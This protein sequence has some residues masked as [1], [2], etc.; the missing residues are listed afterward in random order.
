[1]SKILE[2]QPRNE[3]ELVLCRWLNAPRENVYRAWT[4][5]RIMPKWFAPRPWTTARVEV[6]VRAGGSTLVV[7]KSPEGQE[8]PC[9][10]IYLEVIPGKKIVT[11]DAYTKAWEPSAK[12]FMT[13][14]LTFEDENGGTRYTARA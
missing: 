8:M 14:E 13:L 5:P 6:D 9:P 7:M 4:D 10:G 12:P 1:M 11:T 2:A 3:R